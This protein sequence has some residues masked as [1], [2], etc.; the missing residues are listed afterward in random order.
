MTDPRR[1]RTR[2]A[3]L[4]AGLGL[5]AKLPVD[6]V[7]IDEITAKAGV[8]KGSFYNHFE[9][10]G[11]FANAIVED[12]QRDIEEKIQAANCA[13]ASPAMR[14]ARAIM[15]YAD[16]AMKMPQQALVLGRADLMQCLDKELN[17]NMVADIEQ[18]VAD[19]IFKVGSIEAGKLF[20]VGGVGMMILRLAR[21]KDTGLAREICLEMCTLFLCCLGVA[22]DDALQLAISAQHSLLS[23]SPVC[24]DNLNLER[25]PND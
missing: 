4:D 25:T 24:C 23:I 11:A 20:L 12:I 15:L 18:G 2:Q 7:A 10:R 14:V 21:E 6:A 22:R 17:D 19:R 5:F 16:Y 8:G 1:Q 9:S 13:I 3:L